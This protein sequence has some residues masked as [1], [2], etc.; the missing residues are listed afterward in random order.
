MIHIDMDILSISQTLF[1]HPHALM[2]IAKCHED[3]GLKKVK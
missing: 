2:I 3:K 1:I